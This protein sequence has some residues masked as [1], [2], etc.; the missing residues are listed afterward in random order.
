[1]EDVRETE[2]ICWAGGF[3]WMEMFYHIFIYI[4]HDDLEEEARMPP[5]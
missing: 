3:H 2:C 5:V 4:F 1:M